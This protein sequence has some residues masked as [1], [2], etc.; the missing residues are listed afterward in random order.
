[1]I[2]RVNNL[3]NWN[4]NVTTFRRSNSYVTELLI[5]LFYCCTMAWS[6]QAPPVS[7]LVPHLTWAAPLYSV[8]AVELLPQKDVGVTLGGVGKTCCGKEW[9]ASTSLHFSHDDDTI[10]TSC[11]RVCIRAWSRRVTHYC[12]SHIT[13]GTC[14][15]ITWTANSLVLRNIGRVRVDRQI[16]VL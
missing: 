5:L 9:V 7:P 8:G 14:I 11:P 15:R 1:M 13:L 3:Q 4:E 2:V 12:I 10:Y 16:N 6:T